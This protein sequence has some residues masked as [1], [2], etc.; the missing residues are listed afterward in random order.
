MNIA[1]DAEALH[2][3]VELPGFRKDDI[4]LDIEDGRLTLR[5][6][7]KWE[8]TSEDKNFHQVEHRYGAFSRSF[9]LPRGVDAGKAEAEYTD[10]VLRIVLPKCEPAAKNRVQIKG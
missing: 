5:A 4:H 7:R 3:D 1:E 9:A 6:E 8:E 2:F 10:G